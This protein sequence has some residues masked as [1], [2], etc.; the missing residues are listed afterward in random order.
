MDS[1]ETLVVAQV[2]VCF[3]SVFGH[4]AFSVL[5]G[6]ERS[7]IYVYV[8]VKFLD[9]DAQASCLKEFCERCGNDAFAQ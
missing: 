7:G 9:S 8:G 6:I 2:K 5:I 3:G 1:E 4:V